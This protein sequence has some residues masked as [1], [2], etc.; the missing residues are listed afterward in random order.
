[1][2]KDKGK[3]ATD[4]RTSSTYFMPS[5][6]HKPLQRIDAR[7]AELSLVPKTHQEYVQVLKYEETQKYD[8]HHDYFDPRL[9]AKDKNT[10]S[11]IGRGKK[12][13]MATVLW[14]LSDVEGGGET[15]FPQSGGVHAPASMTSCDQGLKVTPKKGKVIMFYSLLPN[16]MGDRYSLHGACPVEGERPKWAANKWVWSYP[17]T[18]GPGR[19]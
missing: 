16:G 7:V 15:V 6:P 13:R 18:F 17:I 11:M 19:D 1:M 12:N 10:L 2:D 9:Y 14:Y 5:K 4:W 8:A 3:A